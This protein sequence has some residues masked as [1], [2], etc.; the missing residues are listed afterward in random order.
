MKARAKEDFYLVPKYF[1]PK[2]KRQTFLLTFTEQPETNN[3]ELLC[4]E[5]P[6]TYNMKHT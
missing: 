5:I 2:K 4:I 3:K 1:T 6:K